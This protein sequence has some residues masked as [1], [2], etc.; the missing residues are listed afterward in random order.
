MCMFLVGVQN[1][2]HALLRILGSCPCNF[3]INRFS[4]KFPN[5]N[6]LSRHIEHPS[7]PSCCCHRHHHNHHYPLAPSPVHLISNVVIDSPSLLT[8]TP[9]S[10]FS[11]HLRCLSFF[12]FSLSS[13]QYPSQIPPTPPPSFESQN[14]MK[15]IRLKTK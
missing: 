7:F 4:V 13:P 8:D 11:L 9:F 3:R 1:L 10:R 14:W 5:N 15:L 6:T 2:V 12:L